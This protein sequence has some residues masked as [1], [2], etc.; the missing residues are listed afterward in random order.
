MGKRLSRL[1]VILLCLALVPAFGAFASGD[2]EKTAGSNTTG[3][4]AASG[5]VTQLT[6]EGYAIPVNMKPKKHLRIAIL[7]LENNPAWMP[8]KAA[9][10][11]VNKELAAYDTTVD[12]IIPAEFH[13]SGAFGRA[14]E[15]CLTKKYDAIATLAPDA[16]IVPFINKAV[17]SGVPVATFN[18]ETKEPNKRLFFVGADLYSQ[19]QM[20]AEAMAKTLNGNGKVGII[21]GFFSVEGLE[22]RRLGFV[23]QLKKKYP[24]IQIVGQVENHDQGDEAFN[25]TKDFM[26]ANP[27]LNGIYVTA[28]GPFGAGKAVVEAGKIGKVKV[29]CFD[30]VDE[31]MDGVK[32]GSIYATIGQDMYAQ[33]HDPAVRLYNYLVAGIVPADPKLFTNYDVVTKDNVDKYYI[34]GDPRKKRPPQ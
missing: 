21:T 14:I 23:D 33:G 19:G 31:T 2:K 6:P 22:A 13:E 25:Q 20:A 15:D 8:T 24:G 17:E 28:G 3:K 1:L 5:Q 18:V 10:A 34:P 4:V 26:S 32:N 11:D 7:G 29:V 27:D 9:A 30:F 12:W 16:G